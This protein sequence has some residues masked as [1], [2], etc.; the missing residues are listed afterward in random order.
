MEINTYKS[1]KL[2]DNKNLEESIVKLGLSISNED[3]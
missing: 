3:K 2:E 1:K